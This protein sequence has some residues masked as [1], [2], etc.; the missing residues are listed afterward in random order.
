MIEHFLLHLLAKNKSKNDLYL[1]K[2]LLLLYTD[3]S[4][5]TINRVLAIMQRDGYIVIA[6]EPNEMFKQCLETNGNNKRIKNVAVYCRERYPTRMTIQITD[7]GLIRYL[8]NVYCLT[9]L[10]GEDIETA[11]LNFRAAMRSIDFYTEPP[12]SCNNF[13]GL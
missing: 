11:L 6:E 13:R 10:A 9:L 2:T 5:E 3:A 4:D 12:S 7:L 1:I 8:H